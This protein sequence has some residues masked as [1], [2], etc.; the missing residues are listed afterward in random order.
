MDRDERPENTEEEDR[1][2]ASLGQHLE[3]GSAEDGVL[4]EIAIRRLREGKLP[5]DQREA[6]LAH[7]AQD[8][9]AREAWA[10]A[11]RP[12]PDEALTDRVTQAVLDQREAEGLALAPR[13]SNRI[14]V[15]R[16]G[17]IAAGVAIGLLLLP[18]LFD[19]TGPLPP[20]YSAELGGYLQQVRGDDD[21]P[22]EVP[23][24]AAASTLEVSLRPSG[25][26]QSEV[27]LTAWGLAPDGQL[28]GLRALGIEQHNGVFVIH[29]RAD[30][31]FG[32]LAGTW[33]LVFVLS[34]GPPGPAA[35]WVQSQVDVLDTDGST[36][37]PGNQRAVTLTVVYD[38]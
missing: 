15:L 13:T 37:L 32:D 6:L 33:R 30:E 27:A 29:G 23:T 36:I 1:L 19:R 2:L 34:P 18:R 20:E 38:P 4:D 9:D 17:A 21:R 5:P 11:S 28:V 22:P 12:V 14:R 3:P 24:Y 16:W 10:V 35:S 8:D 26:L 31:V 25:A 7:L